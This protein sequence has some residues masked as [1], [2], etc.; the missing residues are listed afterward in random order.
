MKI[1]DFLKDIVIEA[2]KIISDDFEINSK[3]DGHDLVTTYDYEVEKFLISQINKNYPTFSIVSEEFNTNSKE[4]DNCFIIDPI[5][6]TVNFANQIPFWG[7]QV[8]CKKDSEICAAV[9]YLPKLNELFWA[10]ETGA[11]LNDKKIS[12][13]KYKKLQYVIYSLNGKKSNELYEEIKN[14]IYSKR[15]FGAC[16]IGYA[17][18]ACGRLH[19]EYFGNDNPW[20]YE[21]GMFIAKQAGAYTINK[22]GSHIAASTEELAKILN[23]LDKNDN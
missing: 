15:H 14:T 23:I 18:V 6:G 13:R 17:Y 9:I 2:S 22:D 5:D 7:I 12:V 20:D 16:C 4:T 8:A 10:D 1:I 19:G 11:Y 21:P 3:D